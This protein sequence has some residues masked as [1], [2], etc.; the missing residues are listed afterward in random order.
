MCRVAPT[1]APKIHSTDSP[2][3]SVERTR[4][5]ACLKDKR[6]HALRLFAPGAVSAWAKHTRERMHS[7]SPS[8]W[9]APSHQPERGAQTQTPTLSTPALL[10]HDALAKTAMR[11]Q[12]RAA[13]GGECGPRVHGSCGGYRATPCATISAGLTGAVLKSADCA[14]MCCWGTSATRKSRTSSHGSG[15]SL[16]RYDGAGHA[17]SGMQRTT[18]QTS[19]H[20]FHCAP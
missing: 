18:S 16:T 11:A 4:V 9:R 7:C 13:G 8:R 14:A 10:A 15:S 3:P 17:T 5:R 6:A 20:R 12:R 1:D 19:A 2:T